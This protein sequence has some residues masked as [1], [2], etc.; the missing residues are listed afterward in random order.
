VLVA[1]NGVDAS[2]EREIPAE[3]AASS[4]FLKTGFK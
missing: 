3:A 1:D 2:W 4:L